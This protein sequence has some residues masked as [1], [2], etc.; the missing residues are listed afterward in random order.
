[1][2][3][4]KLTL[5][6]F[7]SSVYVFCFCVDKQ[8]HSFIV[9]LQYTENLAASI[10]CQSASFVKYCSSAISSCSIF[11][12]PVIATEIMKI[13]SSLSNNKSPGPDKIGP[14]LLKLIT[15]NII[16]PRVSGL[17]I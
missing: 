17:Y 10:K 11:T 16:S 9:L 4:V 2:L 5:C 3:G 1:L 14:K 7:I 6:I 8:I 15:E 12:E 13:I